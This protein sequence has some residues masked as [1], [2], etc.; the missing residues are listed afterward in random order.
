M[1]NKLASGLFDKRD[2]PAK[3]IQYEWSGL[4]GPTTGQKKEV[5]QH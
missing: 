2:T 5:L 1:F 4:F 3:K